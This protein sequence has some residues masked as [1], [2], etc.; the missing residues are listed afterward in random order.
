MTKGYDS[1][2][3]IAVL[4][5]A[6]DVVSAHEFVDQKKHTAFGS[7]FSHP[8]DNVHIQNI[9]LSYE[10]LR[11]VSG[12]YSADYLR[13]ATH[14]LKVDK[15]VHSIIIGNT[16]FNV[17][18][19][20]RIAR[21]LSVRRGSVSIPI[22]LKEHVHT[23]TSLSLTFDIDGNQTSAPKYKIKSETV[24]INPAE[25]LD[26][27]TS[28]KEQKI[29]RADAVAILE[30][31]LKSPLEDD[32]ENLSEQFDLDR[33]EELYVP[34]FEARLSGPKNKIAIMRVDAARKKI[35]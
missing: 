3:K 14:A 7:S 22:T 16:T 25:V 35:I 24:E 11:T 32:I 28:V 19:K 29:D 33:I 2:T 1:S 31:H 34:I 23:N 4:R 27:A 20:S 21:A 17:Q 26:N 18:K 9:E 12:S 15:S 6:L 13:N 5:C 10:C 8:K 30:E